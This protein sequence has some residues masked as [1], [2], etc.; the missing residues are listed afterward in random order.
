MLGNHGRT[1]ILSTVDMVV[2]NPN[3]YRDWPELRACFPPQQGRYQ[4]T[5][6]NIGT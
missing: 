3:L 1:E 2:I 6:L 4:E 5:V